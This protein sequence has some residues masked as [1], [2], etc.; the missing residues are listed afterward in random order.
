LPSEHQHFGNNG[1]LTALAA[2]HKYLKVG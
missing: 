1:K 2:G